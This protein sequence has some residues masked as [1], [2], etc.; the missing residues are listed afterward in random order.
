MIRKTMRVGEIRTSIKLENE[1]WAYL[2]EVADGR[3]MRLSAL[4][5]EIAEAAPDRTNLAS[6]LRIFSLTDARTRARTMQRELEK[7]SM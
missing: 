4:V 7:L 6:T 5:N 1:F 3:N 2:K